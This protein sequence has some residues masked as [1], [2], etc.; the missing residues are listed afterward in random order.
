MQNIV[1]TRTSTSG[2]APNNLNVR[3]KF[4]SRRD[5]INEL[6]FKNDGYDYSQHLKEMGGGKFIGKDGKVGETPKYIELPEDVLPST[7]MDLQRDLQA[8]TISAEF[9]DADLHAALFE[10]EDEEGEFEALDDDFVLQVAQE[11]EVPDFDFDAH[12]AALIAKR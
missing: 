8:I 7:G 10:D 12:I 1:Q 6:G 4:E 5:H 2:F 9:M 11:P 3:D